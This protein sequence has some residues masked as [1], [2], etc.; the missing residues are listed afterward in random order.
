VIVNMFQAS[1]TDRQPQTY[2]PLVILALAPANSRTGLVSWKFV[3]H[4]YQC[5]LIGKS[6]TYPLLSSCQVNRFAQ[7]P[8]S[9][10]LS[11]FVLSMGAFFG[12]LEVS[13]KFLSFSS[14]SALPLSSQQVC[15]RWLASRLG[16][17]LETCSP[18]HPIR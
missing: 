16:V 17:C 2:L 5:F 4:A 15:L 3:K 14:L 7:H 13:Q 8:N 11:H 10:S 6:G 9:C 18:S 1:S 12:S